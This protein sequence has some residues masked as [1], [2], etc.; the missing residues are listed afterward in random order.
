M[1]FVANSA[2][3]DRLLSGPFATGALTISLHNPVGI[4]MALAGITYIVQGVVVG[5]VGFSSNG[6]IP[7]LLAFVLDLAWMMWLFKR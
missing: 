1:P 4:A 7:G 2:E 5:A 6:T 3:A